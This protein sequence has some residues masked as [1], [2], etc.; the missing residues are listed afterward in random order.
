MSA[1]KNYFKMLKSISMEKCPDNFTEQV[2]E[3]SGIFACTGDTMD[4]GDRQAAK[5]SGGAASCF[6]SLACI[7]TTVL[8]AFTIN[9]G[10]RNASTADPDRLAK[11]TVTLTGQ[12]ADGM[13]VTF[14]GI[15]EKRSG[16]K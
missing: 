3:K 2:I 14:T 6:Y 16:E 10:V 15:D 11:N 1:D 13:K 7:V 8:I 4:A 5:K 9:I 12:L